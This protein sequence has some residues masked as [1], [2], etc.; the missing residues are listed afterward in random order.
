MLFK[1]LVAVVGV[2]GLPRTL[3]LDLFANCKPSSFS[4]RLGSSV[5]KVSA[6][7]V[8]ENKIID[9]WFNQD[10]VPKNWF[11]KDPAF[12]ASIENNF[13]DLLRGY[14]GAQ[15][16]T[17]P[18]EPEKQLAL[19]I[20]FDQFSRNLYRNSPEAFAYD[21]LALQ[22]AKKGVESGSD[23]MLSPQQRAF[24]YMPFE[25]AEDLAL[26]NQSVMLF[27]ALSEEFPSDTMLKS[28]YNYA[29]RHRDIIEKF[30]RYPHRN[31]VLK[32]ESTPEELAF[33]TKPGSSF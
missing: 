27:K 28:F 17:V 6:P 32:R 10:C 19:V 8:D 4:V 9:F 25:H 23:K 11:V 33:L 12:D 3:N 24:F 18:A 13:G 20:L 21:G 26:Q 15:K 2:F 31:A 14:A 30:G 29:V 7:A 16:L 5:H 22:V 1:L